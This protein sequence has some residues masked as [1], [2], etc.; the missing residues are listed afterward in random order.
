MLTQ[1]IL[2]QTSGRFDKETVINTAKGL[3]KSRI[4]GCDE[5]RALALS[6][7][8][9][10]KGEDAFFVDVDPYTHAL[11]YVGDLIY[12]VLTYAELREKLLKEFEDISENEIAEAGKRSDVQCV[13]ED[14]YFIFRL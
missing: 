2:K 14:E 5:K 6:L 12:W 7:Y 9:L 4:V 8:R 10:E 13:D 1:D 11:F 3:Y